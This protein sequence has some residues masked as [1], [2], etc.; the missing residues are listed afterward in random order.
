MAGELTPEEMSHLT[1]ILQKPEALK[2]SAQALRD[3]IGVVHDEY[4]KRNRAS[5]VDPLLAAQEKYKE[6]KGRKA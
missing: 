6:K 3:Y 1:G 2:S 5:Q 4:T